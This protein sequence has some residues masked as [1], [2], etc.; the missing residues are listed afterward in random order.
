[1]LDEKLDRHG[2]AAPQP[3]CH[4]RGG[5]HTGLC[6]FQSRATK[7]ERDEHGNPVLKYVCL[8]Y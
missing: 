8:K 4:I 5:Y 6:Y 7:T 2:C 1:M 3:L